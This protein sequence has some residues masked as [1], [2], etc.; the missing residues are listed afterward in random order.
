VPQTKTEVQYST[1]FCNRFCRKDSDHMKARNA[2]FHSREL[3]DYESSGLSPHSSSAEQSNSPSGWDPGLRRGVN[4]GKPRVL[5]LPN[6]ASWIVGQMATHIM[7][8][9]KDKYEFWILTDKMVRLRPDLVQALIPEIDFIFPLTD[10]SYKLVQAAAAPLPLPPSIF[11]LHHV[12]TWNPS[13]LAAAND[14]NELIACTSEWK[15]EIARECPGPT[16]TVV[17]HGVDA[18]FFHRVARRRTWFGMP[19]DAFVVGFIGNKTSNYDEGRK[20]LDTL[21]KVTRELRKG[22]PNLHVCFLGLGWDEEVRQFQ[23]Q[24]TS[25]NYTGFIPQSWLPA[26]YSSID[27]H[28]VTSRIEGGPVTVLEAMACETPVVTTRVGLVPHTIVDGKNGF[29]ADIGD[30]ESLVRALHQL[31]VSNQLRQNIGTTARATVYPHMSWEQALG[32]LEEPLARMEA[33]SNRITTGASSA[34][35]KTAAQLAGAVHTMDGLLWGIMS[36]W[37]GLLSPAVAV[38]MVKACWES[39]GTAD[40]LRGLGLITRTAFRRASL[41]RN[42]VI[43]EM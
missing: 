32:E 2:T 24:G 31:S 1:S 14:A 42:L 8:R 7:K 23:K 26:F 22:T 34:S 13:M 28:L 17:P 29:S 39:H 12:T 36:W 18:K 27:V 11:W 6:V 3:N 4:R 19:D 38:R 35:A 20:G 43:Q 21:E 40:V 9:F 10:K 37:E 30:T 41:Q 33:R 16:I 25:A 15:S 5:I